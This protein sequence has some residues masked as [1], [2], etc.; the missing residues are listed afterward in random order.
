M[1]LV[2]CIRRLIHYNPLYWGEKASYVQL[3]DIYFDY[4]H[5]MNLFRTSLVLKPCGALAKF[6][7]CVLN[8]LLY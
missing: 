1:Q 7:E 8:I 5:G 4:L 6:V 3:C 2:L